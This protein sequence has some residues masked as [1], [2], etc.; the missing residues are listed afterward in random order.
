MSPNPITD[1]WMVGAGI[2][3]R[4][5]IRFVCQIARKSWARQDQLCHLASIIYIFEPTL[6]NFKIILIQ[7][8]KFFLFNIQNL[9]KKK[10]K[11]D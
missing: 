10:K 11:Y 4:Y 2:Y 8:S 1:Q 7:N 5:K 3:G 9:K 6:P